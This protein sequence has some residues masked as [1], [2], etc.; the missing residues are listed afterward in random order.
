[1]SIGYMK[2]LRHAGPNVWFIR[3]FISFLCDIADKRYCN[4]I[5]ENRT[6]G[7]EVSG[8]MRRC[9]TLCI[10]K[11]QNKKAGYFINVVTMFYS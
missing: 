8:L 4:I 7:P 11:Q 3:I 5:S 1:M 10:E 9:I 2:K 6:N